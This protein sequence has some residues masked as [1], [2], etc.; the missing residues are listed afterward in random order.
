[1]TKFVW[2]RKT[3]SGSSDAVSVLRGATTFSSSML[4]GQSAFRK[5]SQPGE[6]FLGSLTIRGIVPEALWILK[7]SDSC[8]TVPAIHGK[9]ADS[10]S[11][12]DI[13]LWTISACEAS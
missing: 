6:T 3:G 8:T 4:K 13:S 10:R 12:P 11:M 1:M 9:L 7:I 2:I 5:L